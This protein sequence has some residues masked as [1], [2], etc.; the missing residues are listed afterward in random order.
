VNDPRSWT[1]VASTEEG[2]YGLI[3]VSGLVATSGTGGNPA[4]RTL[5]ITA[6]TVIVFWL[7][8]VYAGAVAA[9]GTAGVEGRPVSL[10]QAVRHAMRRSS[11]LLVATILP[12]IALLLG[13]IGVLPDVVA[14]WTSLWVCVG[15]L[16]WL[17]FAAYR[18]KGA[19]W[20]MQIVGAVS[21]ASFGVVII[22]AKAFVSH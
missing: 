5:V 14:I 20:V 2:V 16:A 8:H 6:V 22:A 7:A 3:L 1:R 4:M 15:V 17:G 12:G 11:G 21:T 19:T 18:R 10:G 13:A 9:H